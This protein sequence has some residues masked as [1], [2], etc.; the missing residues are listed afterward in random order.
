MSKTLL[1]PTSRLICAGAAKAVTMAVDIGKLE[2][3]VGGPR[4]Q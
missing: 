4:F 3:D 2:N 1:T